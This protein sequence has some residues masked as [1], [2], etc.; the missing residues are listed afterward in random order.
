MTSKH[1]LLSGKHTGILL[2]LF[3]MRSKKDWGIG[4]ISS[5]ELWLDF[6]ASANLDILEILPINEM[7]PGVNC[8]YTSMSAFAIDPIYLAIEDIKEL[9]DEIKKEIN[10][11]DFRN[12][13]KRLRNFKSIL[14][15][16]IK[17]LKF[18]ILWKIYESFRLRHISNNT[19]LAKNYFIFTEQ[20]KSW[21]DDYALFRKIKDDYGRVSWTDW[22]Q[23]LRDRELIVL[24]AFKKN[25]RSEIEFFK[26]LQWLIHRQW[27]KAKQKAEKLNIKLFGDLPFMVNQDSADVW[28]RQNEFDISASIGAPPDAFSKTGQKWGLPAY[29]WYEIEKNNFEW[30][31]TKVKKAEDF[32]HIYRLDHMVGFFRTWIVP[33]DEKIKPYFDIENEIEQRSRGKRFLQAVLTASSCLP[34]AEDLGLIPPYVGEILRELNVPGY[35]VMRWQK[36]ENQQEY[37][38][39][40]QYAKISLATT[41]T[42]DNE[43]LKEWWRSIDLKEKKVFWRMIKGYD[44]SPPIFK[45]AH[46]EI[47]KKVLKARSAIVIL[48][49][50][51]ILGTDERVNIPNTMGSHNWSYRFP[52]DIE[53]VTQNEKISEKILTLKCLIKEERMTDN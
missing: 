49:M 3:S 2:P 17:K 33:H 10:S 29:R 32:Y 39:P 47:V 34:A 27:S 1:H 48:P 41:S 21:L 22:P 9:D 44:G 8:P 23:G 7:P 11:A 14:Y 40:E 13:I 45:K 50:Q 16:D 24:N 18:P 19:E 43:T 42:H 35:K 31:R 51:D 5:L 37:I 53:S 20:N 25:H 38:Q 4:D 52:V 6:L 28:S 26:Y 15:D 36:I 46:I 12:K 30:W